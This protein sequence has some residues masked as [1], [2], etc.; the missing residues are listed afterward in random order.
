[1]KD[2]VCKCGSINDYRTRDKI[3][4]N[5]TKHIEAVCNVCDSHITFIKQLD[6]PRTFISFGKYKGL[7]T[8]QIDDTNYLKWLLTI[9]KDERLINGVKIRLNELGC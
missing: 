4:R 8:Y 2:I 5:G 6:K 9:V 3:F 1:M 7:H